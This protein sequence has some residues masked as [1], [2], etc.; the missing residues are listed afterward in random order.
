M[1]ARDRLNGTSA[2]THSVSYQLHTDSTISTT[3]QFSS[4]TASGGRPDGAHRQGF[5]C[6]DETQLPR[7]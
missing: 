6:L 2:Y 7:T 3:Q 4:H 1:F 5:F